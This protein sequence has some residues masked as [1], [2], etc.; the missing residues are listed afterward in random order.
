MKK[1]TFIL[2]IAFM[3]ISMAK[4]S[5]LIPTTFANQQHPIHPKHHSHHKLH[6][7]FI[8]KDTAAM[9]GMKPQAL[10]TE[11]KKGKTLLQIVQSKGIT[12]QQYIHKLTTL[13]HGHLNQAVVNKSITHDQAERL[14]AKLPSV[15]SRAIHHNWQQTVPKPQFSN[16]SI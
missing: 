16:N 12:E 1:I 4:L 13:A 2:L 9:I 15:L 5:S 7:G 8:V 10:I 6:G 11:L 14:K 3:L